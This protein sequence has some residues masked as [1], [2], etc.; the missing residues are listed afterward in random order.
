MVVGFICLFYRNSI[1]NAV[2]RNQIF[3]TLLIPYFQLFFFNYSGGS[4]KFGFLKVSLIIF[5]LMS[6][7]KLSAQNYISGAE[8]VAYHA[9]TNQYFI[10]SLNNN[11]IVAIDSNGTQTIFKDGVVA[12]GNCIKGDTLFVSSG[13]IARGFNI[14]TGEQIMAVE[15]VGAVGLDGMTTDDKGFLYVVGPRISKIF[16]IDI[17]GKT[18]E[19]FTDS[20]LAAATQDIIFDPFKNRLIVAAWGANTPIIQID[21]ENGNAS[22]ITEPIYGRFDGVTISKEG[23][24]YLSTHNDSGSVIMF[25]NDFNVGPIILSSGYEEP[26]GLDYN[27]A[28]NVI[29]VP[30]FAGNSISFINLPDTYFYPWFE[31]DKIS[32]HA[33]LEVEFTE[34]CVTNLEVL[35]VEWDFDNDG[36]IDAF[37]K[38][39]KFVYSTPGTYSV[40]M[41]ASVP[42]E[43]KELVREFVIDVFD[44]KSSIKFN[45]KKEKLVIPANEEINFSDGFTIELLINPESWGDGIEESLIL[46]KEAIRVFINGRA[47]GAPPDYTFGGEF[48]FKN[49][50]ILR[51][52]AESNSLEL[53]KWQH[54]ALSFDFNS[55]EIKFYSNGIEKEAVLI[56]GEINALPLLNNNEIDL[57]LGIRS[58]LQKRFMGKMDEVRI[59]NEIRTAE[60]IEISSHSNLTGTEPELVAS[61]K[62]DEGAGNEVFSQK[63]NKL[64]GYLDGAYFAQG[65]DISTF[66]S[67]KNYIKL[68][69]ENFSLAQNYPNPFN[70]STIIQYS[71]KSG[72]TQHVTLYVY[73][74]LGSK[75]AT[76]VNEYQPAGN[77]KVKFDGSSVRQSLA[78]GIYFYTLTAGNFTASRKMVLLK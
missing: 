43:K 3:E 1:D 41:I 35:N 69:P 39:P 72:E 45:G 51:I 53:N 54:I 75:V 55:K 14:I 9:A 5:I 78:S 8:S 42:L 27:S 32:G 4:M 12:F 23:F 58:D 48:I 62:F 36:N 20:G 52:A 7:A 67:V 6:S 22:D 30:S 37:G 66:T 64:T 47:F 33:P 34:S 57:I 19:I 68:A 60:Q 76:L 29:A 46:D 49:S 74:I 65:I 25:D 13:N 71:I 73:N 63:A 38:N 50:T 28:N 70:P 61:W 56:N 77:Y 18:S 31:V 40:K 2:N 24:V 21:L 17:A 15:C 10:S 44:G 59:W 11:R 26:A 16:K